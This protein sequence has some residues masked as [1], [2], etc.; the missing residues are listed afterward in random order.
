MNTTNGKGGESET[1]P[2]QNRIEC[3]RTMS[4]MTELVANELLSFNRKNKL[5]DLCNDE[6]EKNSDGKSKGDQYDQIEANV[7]KSGHE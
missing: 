1:M 6:D 4:V 3:L 5:D 7:N 2:N